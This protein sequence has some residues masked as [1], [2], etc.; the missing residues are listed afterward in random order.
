M[1]T[2][3]RSW[4]TPLAVGAFTI[5]AVTG[6]LI[7]FDIEIG[8]VEPMHKWL[9]WL[10]VSGVALHLFANWKQ[11]TGYFSKKPALGIIAL[12]LLTTIVSV[13]PIFGEEEKESPAKL[14]AYALASSSLETVAQVVKTTPTALVEEL[15]KKG[16]VVKEATDTV[17][18]IAKNN[19]KEPKEL[20]GDILALS[21]GA[22]V[23][24]D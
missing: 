2:T 21:T 5:S 14:A 11:F 17:E 16:I 6:V 1:S 18:Q 15:G 12:A 8:L 9:S 4:A 7:F 24:K 3:I 13:L 19:G 20:L 10:L 23:D 22:A